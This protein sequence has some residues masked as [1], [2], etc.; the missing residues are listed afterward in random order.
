[1]RRYILLLILYGAIML[2]LLPSWAATATD[3][4]PLAYPLAQY[5]IVLALAIFGGAVSWWAKVRAGQLGMWSL[6][7]LIGELATSAFAGLLTFWASEAAGLPQL[8]TICLVGIAGHMGARA[9][10]MFEA[11]AS[12]RAAAAI[13]VDAP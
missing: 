6:T 3:K 2:H 10:G 1:M 12:K 11:W 5:G 9:I 13:G 4:D 7:H 8:V